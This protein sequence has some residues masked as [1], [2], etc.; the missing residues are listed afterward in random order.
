MEAIDSIMSPTTL[1]QTS[2]KMEATFILI[3]MTSIS[4][5]KNHANHYNDRY[6]YLNEDNHH[7][8]TSTA[9]R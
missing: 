7:D 9:F 8:I 4:P 3:T 1:T 6:I 5:D 2:T